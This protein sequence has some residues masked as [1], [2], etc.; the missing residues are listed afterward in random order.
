MTSRPV[1]AVCASTWGLGSLGVIGGASVGR[2]GEL[3][4]GRRAG[5]GAPRAAAELVQM[6]LLAHVGLRRLRA[7]QLVGL[8][9]VVGDR[10]ER[11][12]H[13]LEALRIVLDPQIDAAQAELERGPTHLLYQ[14]SPPG[15][16]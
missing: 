2:Q 11:E 8:D 3:L 16:R 5:G 4:P 6:L 7:E 12:V 9:L 10:R 13:E 14:R 15:A 1:E